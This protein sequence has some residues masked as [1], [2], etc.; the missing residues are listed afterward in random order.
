MKIAV[1]GV[2]AV[3]ALGRGAAALFEGLCAGATGLA[4][5]PVWGQRGPA[6][7]L[8]G[9][10]ERG[11]SELAIQAVQEAVEGFARPRALAVVG[12]TTSADMRRAEPQWRALSQGEAMPEPASFVW[13]QL[14]HR[15]TQRVAQAIGAQG[16]RCSLSS[17]CT[18]GAAAVGLAAELLLAGRAPA[19]VAFGAD[20]L[21]DT[22]VHGFAS[23]G[24]Y[25]PEPCRPFH[26]GRRGLN[27][28]EGAAALLLE[29]L[30]AALERGARPLALLQGYGNSSDAWRLT[31]PH[32]EGRGAAAAIRAALGH[33]PARR[34][35]WVCAHGTGT[36]LNDAMEARVLG[37]EL[38]QALVSGIKGAV[39]HTLGAAGAL[40]AVVT[41]MGVARG[42]VPP[43]AGPI[44]HSFP[45]LALARQMQRAPLQ[46]AMSVN[47]A[48]GGNNTALL[49][50]AWTP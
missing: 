46:A 17:A 30:Q 48:F 9:G 1:T 42:R 15:P 37:R 6:A 23:L 49:V 40:E 39:G 5:A 27:L 31:A 41:T 47:F 13:P 28:G 12:A 44:D 20:A 34:V 32:P 29:P 43:H 19:A 22:T 10:R 26:Q 36:P 2:G 11:S 4:D 45:E 25:D 33:T 16:P 24:L 7:M 21:C 14:C 18:S 8:P 35:G 3:S 50:G 38:P